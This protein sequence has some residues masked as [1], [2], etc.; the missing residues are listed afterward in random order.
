[1][2]AATRTFGELG[3]SILGLGTQYPPYNLKADS[4]DILSKR[5]YPE[6]PS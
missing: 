1:M 5:F 6:S 4:L 2:M 3:L